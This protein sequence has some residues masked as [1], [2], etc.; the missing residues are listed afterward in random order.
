MSNGKPF[1]SSVPGVVTGVAGVVSAIV[2]LLGVSTQLGWIGGDDKVSSSAD[3]SPTT[4]AATVAGATTA[5]SAA[6]R[7]GE[8]EVEPDSVS[9]EPLKARD[10]TVVVRNTGNVALTMRTPTVTGSAAANFKATD[11]GCAKST[12]A[13]GRSCDVK[14]AFTPTAPGEYAA[15]LVLVASNAPRQVE[16]T[17]KGTATLLG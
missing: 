13:P 11:M 16:V 4:T 7:S 15:V 6:V 10:I 5:P 12:L 2:G 3:G 14:V 8:F 1:W 9:F 17:L